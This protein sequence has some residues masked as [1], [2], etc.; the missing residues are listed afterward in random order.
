M[1]SFLDLLKSI[2]SREHPLRVVGID[3]GESSIKIV[4]L[5]KSDEKAVLHNYGEIALGPRTGSS[6]GQATNL[7]PEKIADALRDLLRETGVMA[8]HVV[9]TIPFKASLLSLVELPDVPAREMETMIPLEARKYIPVPITD[10]SLDWWVL[11]K[12]KTTVV[13]PT[14]P[15]EGKGV[16]APIGKVEVIIAAISNEVLG[17]Y[18]TIKKESHLTG[19]PSHMEVEIFSTLRAIVGRDLAPVLVVDIGAGMTKLMIVEEG[20]VRGSHIASL[21]GQDITH[22]LAKSLN[23]PF[24]QAEEKKCRVGVAGDEEGRDVLAAGELVISSIMNEA[25]RFAESYEQRHQ[26]KIAKVLFVGGG[27]RLKGLIAVAEK[28]FGSIPL[29]I[30]NPFARIDAPA[31]LFA[32]LREIGPN[33]AV[34]IGAA[35]KGLEE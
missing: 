23:I 11:P 26:T 5:G 14:T 27:A 10:V 16:S 13:A 35:L 8:R 29:T 18:D 3:I 2:F 4:E 30:G 31:F 22:A 12:R 15:A 20:V 1:L 28:N 17:R 34:A 21:G 33:F 9:L 24:E 7:P 25:A 6:V 32:T 19:M